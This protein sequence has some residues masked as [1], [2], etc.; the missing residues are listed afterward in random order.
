MIDAMMPSAEATDYSGRAPIASGTLK[1]SAALWLLTA[2]VGQWSFAYVVLAYYG[3]SALHGDFAAWNKTLPHGIVDGEPVGNMAVALHLFAAV[4]VTSC[5]AVQLIPQI[6]A[7]FRAFHHWNGR[8]YLAAVLAASLAGFYM[9]WTRGSAL[10]PVGDVSV[11]IN[12]VLILTFAALALRHAV[13]R[14]IDRHRR[15]VLRLYLVANGVWFFR[16][17]LFFWLF[18]NK[19]PVGF[20]SATFRGPFLIFLGFAQYFV[21]LAALECYLRAKDRSGRLGKYAMAAALLALTGAMAVGSFA[22]TM[23]WMA[24]FSAA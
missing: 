23:R 18:V 5:G 20:D 6:R 8:V 19:G 9:V 16:V 14:N 10:G 22:L 13:A 21:P 1:A 2:M 4:F 17:G 11:S 15:W 12:G 7:R 24:R 3:G